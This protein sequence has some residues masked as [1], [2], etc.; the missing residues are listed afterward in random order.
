MALRQPIT[1]VGL[2]DDY[3]LSYRQVF[4]DVRLY[5]CFKFLHVGMLSPLARKTLPEIAKITG[6]KDGQSLHHFLRDAAWKIEQLRA[7]RV[8]L[9][10]AQIGSRPISLCIDATGDVKKGSATDYVARQYIGNLGKTENGI[11]SVNAYAVLDGITYPLLFKIYKPKSRLKATDES[12][13]KP[14]LAVEI[15]HAVQAMG[16]VIERV[17]A[18]SL[19]GETWKFIRTLETLKLPYIVAIRSNH[20][21]LMPTGQRVRY[22]RWRAYDQPLADHPTQRRYIREIIFGTRCSVRYYQITKG[23]T[24]NPDKADSWFIMTNLTGNI[25]LSVGSQYTLR[26][27]IEMDLPQCPHKSR[28][29]DAEEPSCFG[30]TSLIPLVA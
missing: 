1:T 7:I 10:R 15:V 16:L 20:G 13:T 4:E 12:K 22:H 25:S 24:D 17:L 18:D 2:I 21:V 5:E 26:T 30:L 6:L 3:C 28:F 27:W 8:H 9:I 23:S 19:D 11:V 14:Q 29:V